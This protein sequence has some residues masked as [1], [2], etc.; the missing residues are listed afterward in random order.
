MILHNLPEAE[1]TQLAVR[2]YVQLE[3]KPEEKASRKK[4]LRKTF[5]YALIFDCETT[6]TATQNLRFGNY[7][8]RKKGEI[9]EKGFFYDPAFMDADELALLTHYARE[10]DFKLMDIHEFR[11]LFLK[12]GY[13]CRAAII[14]FNLPFD[15]SQIALNHC[16]ARTLEDAFSLSLS[17]RERETRIHVK[18]I[19]SGSAIIRFTTRP[20]QEQSGHQQRKGMPLQS[21]SGCF[22]DVAT[23]A[24]VLHSNPYTLEGLCKFLK[25]ETVK[26]ATDEHGQKLSVA[27]IKYAVDDVQATWECYQKLKQTYDS[28]Q[29]GR[30]INAIYSEASLGKAYFRDMNIRAWQEIQ[31]DFPAWLIAVIISTYYGG[32]SE[33]RIRHEVVP[34]IYSD[35]RSMYPTVC[36]L[37]N[38]WPFVIAN[39]L[40][41][42]D[43][44][45][46][47]RQFLQNVTLEDLQQPET[48]K[49]LP[50]LVCIQPAGD[51]LPIR[52]AYAKKLKDPCYTIGLNHL[53]SQ[54]PLWYT[55]ADCIAAKLQTGITPK[56]VSAISFSP[57]SAQAD[58]QVI[59]LQGKAEWPVNP[60][61][62]DFYKDLIVRRGMVQSAMAELL[63]EDPQREALDAEQ[64]NLKLTANATSYGNFMQLDQD[65]LAD[66]EKAVY[67]DIHGQPETIRMDFYEKP[68]PCFHPL[69]GTLIT[70][71]AR[72][73]LGV[74]ECL[75]RREGLEWAFCDTDS[76][77]FANYR[78]LDPV[79]FSDKV[80]G[81]CQWFDAL[82]PY[83]DKLP[84]LKLEHYEEG[85][86]LYCW[87]I[88]A[89]RY[90]LFTLD[91]EGMPVIRKASMHGLGQYVDP[92]G[93]D[94]VKPGTRI[95]EEHIRKTGLKRWQLDIWYN[96]LIHALDGN[97]L[98]FNPAGAEEFNTPA[99]CR[100]AVTSPNILKW[101]NGFN[102]PKGIA[103]ALAA[104]IRPFGFI[105]AFRLR[106][107]DKRFIT[108]EADDG[109]ISIAENPPRILSPF[110]KDLRAA[111]RNCF[112][113]NNDPSIKV[114]P[115]RLETLRDA[116]AN[117]NLRP[118]NKFL[119]AR[120]LDRGLTQRRHIE[121]TAI[122]Y[123]G[124][125]ANL[126]DEQTYLGEMP[127][128]QLAYGLG[129][130]QRETMFNGV[131]DAVCK[132]GAIRF[133][134]VTGY[135]RQH[136]QDVCRG[137]TKPTAQTL[138]ELNKAITTVE[139]VHSAEIMIEQ[140]ALTAVRDRME[141]GEITIKV[142][143]D[144][145]ECDPSNLAKVL[146][147]K[148]A[149]SLTIT[150]KLVAYLAAGERADTVDR[151]EG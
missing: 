19:A 136:V 131:L 34:V 148:R 8:I 46:A 116:L 92:Y 33:V 47:T 27:Y 1:P 85:Q 5:D 18:R 104:Q 128:T 78:G 87:A 109:T 96:I 137:R 93:D 138:L 106:K 124:K 149:I 7:Q 62:D 119:N 143:A 16:T 120:P 118:E 56:I 28:L 61:E 58:L 114:N 123:I 81:I 37:M 59:Q 43:S 29:L 72:L 103:K 117:Y 140:T 57:R 51:V 100:Y 26:K 98:D 95:T 15:L 24:R 38:L 9:A 146:T 67:W 105:L 64:K 144:S 66:F 88:S 134:T 142:L 101:L 130:T 65:K 36:T 132:Y 129:K 135:S 75:A 32:R 141:S 40:D 14:G 79:N 71:A 110:N 90:S 91:A 97:R 99:A 121:L 42:A 77:A 80:K 147:G 54:Q 122:E 151:A 10:G 44:T 49:K 4:R 68:G 82:N 39:G 31:P 23:L 50:T 52:A 53:T 115:A 25:V 113:C 73:L 126:I 133:S 30:S 84:L 13:K 125:E 6:T 76:L 83:G 48:W 20:K 69:L 108:I 89:K 17:P 3:K 111:A 150:Q 41:H 112:D 12:I 60:V 35:F 139:T 45:Q 63:Q 21:Y 11:K 107:D 70:G 127:D 55:L 22:I 102:K 2:A 145:L 86:T 94:Y 74:A